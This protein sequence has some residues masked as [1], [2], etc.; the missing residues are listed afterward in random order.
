MQHSVRTALA[1]TGPSFYNAVHLRLR[2][3][4]DHEWLAGG[5]TEGGIHYLVTELA[6]KINASG[7]RTDA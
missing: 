6:V 3:E 2:K 4:S 7:C 5:D 1:K